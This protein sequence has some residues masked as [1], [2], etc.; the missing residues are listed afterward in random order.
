MIENIRQYQIGDSIITTGEKITHIIGQNNRCGVFITESKKVKWEWYA[1]ER[2]PEFSRIEYNRI[3]NLILDT[4]RENRRNNYRIALG[5]A[6]MSSLCADNKEKQFAAFAQLSNKILNLRHKMSTLRF[7]L[8]GFSSFLLIAILCIISCFVL[9]NTENIYIK[10]MLFGTIG[11]FM[12]SI[13]TSKRFITEDDQ[14]LW[15]SAVEGVVR[16]LFGALCGTT[17][18]LLIKS[19]IILGIFSNIN[20]GI[21]IFALMSGFLERLIPEILVE[22]KNKIKINTEQSDSVDA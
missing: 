11:A 7:L 2:E 8:G 21:Y 10:S 19:N 6:M 17:A 22:M 12:S 9:N 5:M 15:F 4:I 14:P 13:Q 16:V 1:K 3:A 20:E 18:C